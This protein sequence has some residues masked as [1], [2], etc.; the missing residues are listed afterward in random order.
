MKKMIFALVVL[1][2]AAPVW[3]TTVTIWC[4]QVGDTNQVEIWYETGGTLPRAFGL[5]ITVSDANILACEPAIVGESTAAAK[6]YGIFPGTINIDGTGN[7]TH[8]GSPV[9]PQ[10]ELPSDTRAG[11][12]TSQITVEIGSLYIG[13]GDAPDPC[14][15]LCTLAV[16]TDCEVTIAANV[17]RAGVGVIMEDPDEIP[18]V[19]FRPCYVS[20]FFCCFYPGMVDCCGQTTTAAHYQVYRSLGSPSC[21]CDPCHCRGDSNSDCQINAVD[22]LALRSAWPGFGGSYDPCV[23]S[24]YDGVINAVDVLNLRAAWPGFGGP[25]CTGCPPC[26]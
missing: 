16:R 20:S 23:D 9:A 18:S 14:G 8:Y 21:W 26:P 5:D 15:L 24:N 6:G 17:S 4:E 10:S 3:A 25:G 2:F 7:V 13:E 11:L 12:G 1:L 22:V 19:V